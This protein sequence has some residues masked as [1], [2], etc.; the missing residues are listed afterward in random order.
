M[1]SWAMSVIRLESK[2]Y[3]QLL[4]VAYD[5]LDKFTNYNNKELMIINKDEDGLH[6]TITP[7]A[8]VKN[9][10]YE[11]DL[12]LRNNL[13][14]SDRPLGLYHPREEYW[15]IK[16][17]NIG[18]IEVMGLAILPSRLNKEM[19]YVKK[20]LLDQPLTDN[21]K[22]DFEK[23]LSWANC[24]KENNKINEENVETI[25]N[26]GIG[27]VFTKVL[28]DCAVFKDENLDEFERFILSI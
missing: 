11:L 14:T 17:E 12:V 23:H 18:L 4:K 19:K 24:L 20:Y 16:K 8:R 3:K 25:I 21:E 6:N 22:V 9:G 27:E 13:I 28:K 7:I 1:L 2:D 5:V 26:N 10:I 15:H